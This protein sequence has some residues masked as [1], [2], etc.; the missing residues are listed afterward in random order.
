MQKEMDRKQKSIFD[1]PLIALITGASKGIGR[2]IAVEFSKRANSKLKLVLTGRSEKDL[3]ETVSHVK[4]ESTFSPEKITFKLVLGCLQDQGKFAS[5]LD[6]LF[7]IPDVS[8]YQHAILVNNAAST[9]DVSKYIRD[10]TSSDAGNIQDYF[11]LNVSSALLLASKFLSVF[12]PSKTN[13]KEN[14]RLF[15]VQITSLAATLPTPSWSLYCTGKAARDMLHKV[16]A[17]EEPEARV[18]SYAPG[19]VDTAMLQHMVK[20]SASS[21][22]VKMMN[23]CQKVCVTP[24]RTASVLCDVLHEDTYENGAHL[25]LFDVIGPP[26]S[27]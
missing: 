4:A 7:C 23:G 13:D 20:H 12:S 5:L 22:T 16:I 1:A 24:Q 17:S 2:A 26:K 11:F 27:D 8:S 10:L 18:L 6:E 15:L 19:P 25:D 9:G 21:Q 14:G 3:Q